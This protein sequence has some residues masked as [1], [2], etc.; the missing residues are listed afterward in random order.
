VRLAYRNLG[1]D[2]WGPGAPERESVRSFCFG[3]V[4]CEPGAVAAVIFAWYSA[5][6]IAPTRDQDRRQLINARSSST[7]IVALNAAGSDLGATSDRERGSGSCS[8]SLLA[9]S[10]SS[11]AKLSIDR[12]RVAAISALREPRQRDLF[13]CGGVRSTNVILSVCAM[14]RRRVPL[15]GGKR[16]RGLER[17]RD[18]GPMVGRR[19]VPPSRNT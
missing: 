12:D 18:F 19:S 5:T 3:S 14:F 6:F 10:S 8:C 1:V 11:W 7:V 13:R 17:N 2:H 15:Q 9:R 4:G 16:P